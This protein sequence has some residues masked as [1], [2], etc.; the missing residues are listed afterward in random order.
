[1]QKFNFTNLPLFD[2]QHGE[3]DNTK[4]NYSNKNKKKASALTLQPYLYIYLGFSVSKVN[5]KGE[6]INSQRGAASVSFMAVG[7]TGI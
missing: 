7:A 6:P 4:H 1:M 5:R 2:R 3:L